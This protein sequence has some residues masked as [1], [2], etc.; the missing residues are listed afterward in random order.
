VKNLLKKSGKNSLPKIYS[1]IDDLPQWNWVQIHKTNN[2]AY[3]KQLS[4][5]SNLSVDNS[6]TLQNIWESIYNEYLEEFGLTKE[7]K[8]LLE[9]KINLARLKNEFIQT[10]NRSLLNFIKIEAIELEAMF[11]TSDSLGFEAVI[12]NIEKIQQFHIDVKKITVYEY[13]NY[14]RTLK[15]RKNG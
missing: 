9:K 7:Y 6:A 14:L 2:L 10:D 15:E 1:S 5:Y 12:V 11:E 3:I 13:H 8:E 4:S